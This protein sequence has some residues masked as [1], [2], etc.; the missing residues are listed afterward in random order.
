MTTQLKAMAADSDYDEMVFLT[1]LI[2]IVDKLEN[3]HAQAEFIR[4]LKKI[5]VETR[6][7]LK[8]VTEDDLAPALFTKIQARRIISKWKESRLQF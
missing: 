2:P 5:G 1:D 7:D 3:K 6:E 8:L 4:I